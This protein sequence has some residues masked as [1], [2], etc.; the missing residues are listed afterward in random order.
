VVSDFTEDEYAALQRLIHRV[1][2][3]LVSVIE[4]ERLYVT[5]FGSQQG[6]PHVHWHLLPLPPGVLY[7]DQQAAVFDTAKG[8][9][10]L[11]DDVMAQLAAEVR[12]ALAA[13]PHAP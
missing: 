12:A 10:G 8:W 9:M 4:T 1:G 7:D 3:A 5:S 13:A 2:R 6:N 11:G